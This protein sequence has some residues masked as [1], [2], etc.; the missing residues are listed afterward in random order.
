MNFQVVAAAS[1]ALTWTSELL[2]DVS[3]PK[4]K[5]G[6]T[7]FITSLHLLKGRFFDILI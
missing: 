2:G 7:A 3:V 1:I 6:G 5:L 4:A